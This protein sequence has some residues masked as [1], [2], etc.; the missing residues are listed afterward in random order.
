MET[1]WI[2]RESEQIEYCV[3]VSKEVDTFDYRVSDEG[4]QWLEKE[5]GPFHPVYFAS[6]RLWRMKPFYMRFG[7]GESEGM[8]A[9]GVS[10][11]EG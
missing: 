1:F 4:Y 2:S 3:K 8:D 5:F 9:F 11:K 10:W 6:N 7:C